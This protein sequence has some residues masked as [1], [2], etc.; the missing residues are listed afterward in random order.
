MIF[1]AKN[2][3][4][5][6]IFLLKIIITKMII[7]G[8]QIGKGGYGIVYKARI[9]GK[10]STKEVAIKSSK[11]AKKNLDEL[12]ALKSIKGKHQIKTYKIYVNSKKTRSIIIMELCKASL[13][14]VEKYTMKQKFNFCAQ[15]IKGLLEIH[16]LGYSH[17]DIKPANL[18]ICSDKIVKYSDFGLSTEKVIIDRRRGTRSYMAPEVK[19]SGK[20]IYDTQ[21]ADIWSLGATILKITLGVSV[22]EYLNIQYDGEKNGKTP[23]DDALGLSIAS[24]IEFDKIPHLK[25]YP[26][27]KKVL[28]LCLIF[29]P[30]MRANI[31]DLLETNFFLTYYK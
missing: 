6:I 28:K 24:K 8:E 29:D 7:I 20:K 10:N 1:Q 12:Y 31:Y 14:N 16:E 23:H 25:K 21:A 11:I 13:S 19:Y 17:L 9:E 5:K 18:L 15:A 30:M 3:F 26:E 4:T 2:F 27:L 22:L